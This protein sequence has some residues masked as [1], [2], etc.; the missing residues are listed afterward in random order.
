MITDVPGVRCGHWTDASARTGCTVALLP[1]GTVAS[2]EVRGGA[3]ASR[4]LEAL[5]VGRLVDNAHAVVLTGGSAYGLAAADGVMAWCEE[6]G[7]GFDVGVAVVPI[8]PALGIFDLAVGDPM[9]RPGPDQGRAACDAANT[10]P[11]ELGQ[12]GAGTG[13]TTGKSNGP[14][15]IRPGGIGSS[16]VRLGG[17]IVSSLV[18]VNSFGNID[19]GG[20]SGD[21][22]VAGPDS[23][24]GTNTTIG[25][26]VTNARL[27]KVGC[28]LL[29]QGAHDGLARSIMPPHTR[30]DGDAFVAAATGEIDLGTLDPPV[31]IDAVRLLALRSVERAIRSLASS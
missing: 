20:D 10:G 8:V 29:A 3:P 11:V 28:H 9:V 22:S 18:V 1:S 4:E 23:T 21:P 6:Q 5:Q 2:A 31:D 26:I 19:F 16:T 13:A 24:M 25:L 30:F 17:L 27:D 15:G 12:V 14:D 7:I